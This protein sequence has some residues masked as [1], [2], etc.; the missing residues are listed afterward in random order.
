MERTE[1]GTSF[2][3]TLATTTGTLVGT[4]AA[5]LVSPLLQPA[6]AIRSSRERSATMRDAF[7][8]VWFW[9]CIFI[10]VFSPVIYKFVVNSP[11]AGPSIYSLTFSDGRGHCHVLSR[12]SPDTPF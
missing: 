9:N 12:L 2:F 6:T 1:T 5:T 3:T 8:C 4:C 10:N 11:R 7:D